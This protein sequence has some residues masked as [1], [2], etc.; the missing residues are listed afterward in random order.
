MRRG[1][2]WRTGTVVE[3]EAVEVLAK[4]SA[5]SAAF[6]ADANARLTYE[7]DNGKWQASVAVTNMTGMV[8]YTNGFAFLQSGTGHNVIARRGNGNSH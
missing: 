1:E 2:R 5:F 7:S 8:Y 3:R 4:R 6:C